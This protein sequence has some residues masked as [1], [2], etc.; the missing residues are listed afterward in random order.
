MLLRSVIFMWCVVGQRLVYSLGLSYFVRA[1]VYP[2]TA[3]RRVRGRAVWITVL[4]NTKQ[5]SHRVGRN[6]KEV[7]KSPSVKMC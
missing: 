3:H 7:L 2:S 6:V 4:Y 5:M 1:V